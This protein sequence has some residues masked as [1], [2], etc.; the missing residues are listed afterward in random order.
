MN[1]AHV[2]SKPTHM[3]QFTKDVNSDHSKSQNPQNQQRF[4]SINQ[5]QP[6]RKPHQ[7]LRGAIS[8][9]NTINGTY[10]I[11]KKLGEGSF[12]VIYQG[13]NIITKELIAIKF[14]P[15]KTDAPQL[16]DEYKFYKMINPAI[17]FPKCYYFGLEGPYN[18]LCIEL[19]G[20]S[21]E[22][23]FGFCG[24][25]FSIKTVC[26]AAKQMIS[27]IWTI[28][29]HKY[30]YRDI[31]PDNFLIGKVSNAPENHF[32][33]YNSMPTPPK[34]DRKI[35]DYYMSLREKILSEH[36]PENPHLSSVIY[37][38]DFGMAKQ[39]L[40]PITQVHIPYREKKS[41]SGTARYMSINTHMGIEQSRRDDLEALGH[42]LMYFLRGSLP[43][44]GLRGA[45]HKLKYEKIGN[46]KQTTP[47]HILCAGY[48]KEFE[49]YLNYTR[50]LKFSETPNYKYL[51]KLFDRV[52]EKIGEKD[53][54]VFDWMIEMDNQAEKDHLRETAWR[55]RDERDYGYLSKYWQNQYYTNCS[56]KNK[57]LYNHDPPDVSP[58][59][60]ITPQLQF[61]AP[62]KPLSQLSPH[63]N[64]SSPDP[65][66]SRV[67]S[68]NVHNSHA[69]NTDPALPP[70][71]A[72]STPPSNP[73]ANTVP[74]KS[75]SSKLLPP[76]SSSEIPPH[77]LPPLPSSSAPLVISCIE[78]PFNPPL[79]TS[80]LNC[81]NPIVSSSDLPKKLSISKRKSILPKLKFFSK[82][83]KSP[84]P[85][86][87][88][89]YPPSNNVDPSPVDTPKLKPH[90]SFKDI[91]KSKWRKYFNTSKAD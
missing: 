44:Q 33:I 53:D 45:T 14:E 48:P 26:M 80:D 47:V 75:S 4:S 20:P 66:T 73:P 8:P 3:V 16:A 2:S 5:H 36:T 69:S 62:K 17:G 56:K 32:D 51:I 1:K 19:L 64:N 29:E 39:Y 50:T 43:W 13:T 41:L 27:R 85:V 91:F 31:K 6:N 9:Y 87:P 46:K 78:P 68:S 63:P 24:R 12:G 61:P 54:G 81:P 42:V 74:S 70:D 35:V 28:H 72:P 90:T 82:S 18:V 40:D 77:R 37:V 59:P 11:G 10:S 79:P 25:K 55:K 22:D 38:V 88:H 15:K 58:S 84:S 49:I 23:L 67:K 30:I 52:L 21:L 57:P 71:P 34:V 76:F 89:T 86:Y 83:K 60:P 65:G 7:Q